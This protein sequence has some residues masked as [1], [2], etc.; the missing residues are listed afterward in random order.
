MKAFDTVPHNRLLKKL[1]GYGIN[2]QTRQWIKS[3]LSGRRQR[4]VINGEYSDWAPV[5][6]GIP[7]GSI[8]GPLLFV[9]YINDLPSMVESSMLLF[10]D[11]TK[12]YGEIKD[13]ND[14]TK[15]QQDINQMEQWSDR[16]LLKF[17]PDK[18][19]VMTIGTEDQHVYTMNNQPLQHT[20]EEKDLGVVIDSKL[21]FETHINTKVA[22]ANKIMGIIRRSFTYLDSTIFSRLFKSLVRPHLEYAYPVW[23]PTLKKTKVQIEKVQRRATKQLPC[24]AG[25]EYNERL[26]KLDLPCL[27]YRKLRGDMIEVYKMTSG[28]YDDDIQPPLSLK[29]DLNLRQTRGNSK[30]LRKEMCNKLVKSNYFGNRVTN[31]WNDLPESVIQAP[32]VRAFESR[33]DRYWNRFNI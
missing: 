18:C 27:L 5:S 32:S 3:F 22:T 4:V 16:W 25:L 13:E 15:I 11:D 6:S 8:L 14:N 10:A 23:H 29:E 21:K 24:C 31:F 20:D 9:I 19:K 2:D 28:K 26:R 30:K 12:M 1:T 17:H 7:Q 33:L